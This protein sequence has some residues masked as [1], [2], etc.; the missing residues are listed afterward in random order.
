MRITP[1]TELEQR[2]GRLQA[3]MSRSG[4]DG[5]LVMQNADLYYFTG[6][7]QKGALFIPGTGDAVY[8]VEHDFMRARMECGL[9]HVTPMGRL[10]E[11]SG[12][13]AAAGHRRP[14][15]MGM[16]LDVLPVNLFEACRRQFPES[17]FVDVSPLIRQVRMVKSAY[18]IHIM[19]DAGDQAD[20]IIG[21]AVDVIR[22]GIT[23]LDLAAELELSAR[24]AGHQGVVRT[25]RFNGEAL[26]TTV[27]SGS[28]AAV[29]SYLG[30][31][32]GGLGLNPGCGRGA[33]YRPIGPGDP[34]V[35]QVLACVDG[36]LAAA[37]RVFAIG[38]LDDGWLKAHNDM[39]VVQ[40]RMSEI[41]AVGVSWQEII[42]ECMSLAGRLGH[43]DC[44]LGGCGARLGSGIGIEI[45]ESPVL[46]ADGVSHAL[47][48]GVAFSFGPM[49]VRPGQGATGVENTFYMSYEGLKRLTR[50]SDEPVIL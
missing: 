7:V 26:S 23:D 13:I 27:L 44:F 18:E 20:R 40:H 38:G 28:D 49:V 4:V 35:V 17:R 45:D 2:I 47:E 3:L 30:V 39:L 31:T 41:A 21:R 1:V 14:E 15:T 11:M 8:L 24:K 16:E 37:T 48:P 29:P 5:A 12:L 22:P 25:R 10:A 36:Y 50:S 46:T 19:Q 33:S 43:G 9:R 6:T 32:L 34:V 42:A